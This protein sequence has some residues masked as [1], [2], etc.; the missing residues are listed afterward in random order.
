M[1]PVRRDKHTGVQLRAWKKNLSRVFWHVCLQETQT[2]LSFLLNWKM[3]LYWLLFRCLWGDITLH[4]GFY[5]VGMCCLLDCHDSTEL[6]CICTA[7]TDIC[8]RHS[9]VTGR[10]ADSFSPLWMWSHCFLWT[11]TSALCSGL[12]ISSFF[13][14]FLVFSSSNSFLP[15][16]FIPCFSSHFFTVLFFLSQIIFLLSHLY[17]LLSSYSFFSLLF[18]LF[19]PFP[20]S[21]F[22][23]PFF[24]LFFY[25]SSP[26]CCSYLPF[27]PF[28]LSSLSRSPFIPSF[29]RF[30]LPFS[31]FF[32]SSLIFGLFLH[33]IRSFLPCAVY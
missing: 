9:S 18:P 13:L 27:F 24:L 14:S 3:A 26:V 4:P 19:P 20:T 7:F 16:H 32:H 33:F 30:L 23:W 10:R 12:F 2:D 6:I 17:F 1:N 5:F 25:L 8:R 22:I 11:L 31:H 29:F 15:L 21:F 28:L